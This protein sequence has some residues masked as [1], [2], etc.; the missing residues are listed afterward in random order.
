MTGSRQ[1]AR[2]AVRSPLRRRSR[3]RWAIA[4]GVAV[5]WLVA[6]LMTGSWIAKKGLHDHGVPSAVPVQRVFLPRPASKANLL[7]LRPLWERA[8]THARARGADQP[9]KL[10]MRVACDDDA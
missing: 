4:G 9:S 2:P 10:V 1:A 5:R 7:T 3:R 6:E 8:F